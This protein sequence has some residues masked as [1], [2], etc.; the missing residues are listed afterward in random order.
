MGRYWQ[1]NCP[2]CKAELANG[3]GYGDKL[4]EIWLPFIRCPV[5]G[6]FISTES[7]EYL[8]FLPEERIKFRDSRKNLEAIAN[9]IARTK[10][11]KYVE[12]LE[13][14]GINIYQL[15]DSDNVI[16]KKIQEA[17]IPISSEQGTQSLYNFGIL[18]TEDQ[19]D[20]ATGDLKE[21]IIKKNMDTYRQSKKILRLSLLGGIPIGFLI[22]FLSAILLP[23][24]GAFPLL[25]GL[26]ATFGSAFGIGNLLEKHYKNKEE[27]EN[28][29]KNE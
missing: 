12:F 27:Q 26:L 18:L 4:P 17:G 15:E 28:K 16:I 10:N 24:L 19:I 13:K 25:L 21:D 29:N 11:P 9:S 20:P 2:Y 5:C 23:D 1:L 22:T 3:R 8:S 14:H 7:E 6:K